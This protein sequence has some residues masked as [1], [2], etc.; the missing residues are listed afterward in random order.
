MNKDY[1]LCKLKLGLSYEFKRLLPTYGL[2]DIN[3][4]KLF[5]E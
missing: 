2:T 4:N 3:D 1:N 5:C